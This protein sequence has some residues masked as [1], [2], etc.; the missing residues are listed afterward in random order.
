MF[1]KTLLFPRN[2]SFVGAA[3]CSHTPLLC[4]LLRPAGGIV[5]R[6]RDPL[7]HNICPVVIIGSFCR[8][9]LCFNTTPCRHTPL[10]SAL[11]RPA[12]SRRPAERGPAPDRRGRSPHSNDNR[13]ENSITMGILVGSNNGILNRY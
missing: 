11:L 2:A 10:L 1:E 7:Q 3:L 6:Q 5:S 4:A 13:Y 12:A 8:E 9:F